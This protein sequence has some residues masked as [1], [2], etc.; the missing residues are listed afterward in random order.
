MSINKEQAGVSL[1]YD[2]KYFLGERPC[3]YHKNHRIKCEDCK[4]YLPVQKSILIIKLGATGDVLRTTPILRGLK[5]K[6]KDAHISWLVSEESSDILRDNPYIDR[7]LIHNFKILP[8]LHL[9][10]YDLLINLDVTLESSSLAT[11]I[12]AEEKRGFGLNGRGD[13]TYFNKA[14]ETWHGMSFSDDL[15][16]EN[17]KTY[18][19]IMAD[20]VGIESKKYEMVLELPQEELAFAEE[21]MKK[22]NVYP[23]SYKIGI[24]TGTGGR[25]PLKKWTVEG[26][27]S[28]I[29]QISKEP[30]TEI[31]LF[32][33]PPEK[34]RNKKLLEMF[35]DLLI[36]TGTENSLGQ[37]VALVNQCD[38]I[39]SSDTLI[40]HIAIALKKKTVVLFGPTSAAEIDLYGRGEKILSVMDC[41]CCYK[42]TCEVIPNCMENISPDIVFAAVKRLCN[43][44][45]KRKI[46]I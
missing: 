2:C 39:V 40:M 37:F 12:N 27:A 43:A 21:F 3:S 34:E 41:L 46:K 8:F 23:G 9:K 29:S 28:L 16:K 35:P 33:G 6:I 10:K 38:L 44:I 13:I 14:S 22:K 7:I 1:H 17:Q 25:W 36:D 15:K 5:D 42:N 19:E 45:N 18:Q 4:Y 11:M 32:G 30:N 31:I 24:G 20:I 26:Y